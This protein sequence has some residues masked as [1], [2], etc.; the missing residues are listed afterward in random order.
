M[1]GKKLK[2][3]VYDP[4]A[5]DCA[6]TAKAVR[7]YCAKEKIAA[8]VLE[9]QVYSR[10]FDAFGGIGANSA[11]F[12]MLFAGV[13][14]I[15]DAADARQMKEYA[16]DCPLFIVSNTIEFGVEGFRIRALDYLLKPV[17][18]EGVEKAVGRIG[19]EKR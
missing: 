3:A 1:N 19:A 14:S 5:T 4:D 8:E 15:G 13:D 10:R 9:F 12:D 16:P 11:G 6:A 18:P 7:E 2:I 17:T